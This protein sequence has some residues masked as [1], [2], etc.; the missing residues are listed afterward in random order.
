MVPV[1]LESLHEKWQ[2]FPGESGGDL[3]YSGDKVDGSWWKLLQGDARTI[4]SRLP[5]RSVNT[6]ITSPPYFWQRDY[7]INNQIGLEDTIN[8]YVENLREVFRGIR[9]VLAEDGTVFLNLGDTYYS[10]KGEPKGP[11][12]KHRER[13]MK[14]LRAVDTTGLGVPRKSLIGIPW[15]VA[16]ALIEDGWALRSPIV[17]QRKSYIPEPSA[18]DRP[19]RTYEFIF[20]FSKQPRYYFN[21]SALSSKEEDIWIIEPERNGKTRGLHYAPYPRALVKKCISCGCPKGGVVLDP[22]AGGGTTMS[23][24]LELGCSTVGVELNP[25]FC[26]LI[27]SQLEVS[28]DI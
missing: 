10:A 1:E 19:W 17:W 22:F 8:G 11:D 25:D 13:R 15:R 2:N 9:H 16:L 26:Q 12:A 4:L 21:R 23:V 24:A 20:L 5:S 14:R 27:R 7:N 18:H 6:V 28:L 3:V